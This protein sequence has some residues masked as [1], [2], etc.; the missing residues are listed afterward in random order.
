M[1][2]STQAAAC[3]WQPAANKK[4]NYNKRFSTGEL[5]VE[6][7]RYTLVWGPFCPWATPVSMLIDLLGL[8]TVIGKSQYFHYGIQVSTM[9]GFFWQKGLRW[10]PNFKNEST[11][12]SLSECWPDL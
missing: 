9:T 4:N 7:N 11:F 1:S 8:N 2:E 3:A 5:P 6:P 12:Q 10:G